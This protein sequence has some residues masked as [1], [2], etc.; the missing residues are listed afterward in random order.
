MAPSPKRLRSN[1]NDSPM[2]QSVADTCIS[3]AEPADIKVTINVQHPSPKKEVNGCHKA[4]DYPAVETAAQELLHGKAP[5]TAAVVEKKLEDAACTVGVTSSVGSATARHV[6]CA[7]EDPLTTDGPVQV[8]SPHHNAWDTSEVQESEPSDVDQRQVKSSPEVSYPSQRDLTN[9]EAD[10]AQIDITSPQHCKQTKIEQKARDVDSNTVSTCE[11]SRVREPEPEDL[12][13][14]TVFSDEP[15]EL[16]RVPPQLFWR[17]KDNLCWLDALLVALVNCKR[18]R[19]SRPNQEPQQSPVWQLIKGYNE[20]CAAV[21]AHQQ[22]G[23]DGVVRVPNQVLQ[24]ANSDLQSLRMSV[25]QLLQPKLHCKLGQRE[26]PVFAMPLLL[27]SD[28]WAEPLFQLTFHWEFKCSK[29]KTSTNLGVMKPLPTFTNIVSDWHPLHAAHLA[30]CNVCSQKNQKRTMVL[31]RV[32][33]VFALHFVGGLPDSDVRTYSFTFQGKRYSVTTVIQY[34]QHLKHFVTWIHKPDGSWLEFDDLKHPACT[35]H[36]K[37]PVPAKDIHIVFWEMEVD[38]EPH[39]CS[40]STTVTESPLPKNEINRSLTEKDFMADEL[41]AQSPDQSLLISQNDTDIVCALT[42][43]GENSMNTT[44][45][46]GV[47]TSIGSTTLLDTFEGLTHN[48]IVT[49]TLWEVKDSEPGPLND[50]EQTPDVSLPSRN[51]SP[52]SILTPDSSSTL[53]SSEMPQGPAADD[54]TPHTSDRETV[55][56]SSSD[57]SYV[58]GSRKRPRG[59]GRGRAKANSKNKSR[60][61]GEKAVLANVAQAISPSALRNSE[62]VLP[63]RLEATSQDDSTPPVESTQEVS[64]VSSTKISPQPMSKRCPELPPSMDQNARWSYLLSRHPLN[65]AH[66]NITK[67]IPAHTTDSTTKVKPTVPNHSTPNP[68]RRQR[69]PVEHFSKP[70]LC[71]ED[72]EALLRKAADMY[73]AFSAKKSN[74]STLSHTPLLP[75]LPTQKMA[76]LAPRDDKSKASQSITPF[77]QKPPLNASTVS[78]TSPS[79]PGVTGLPQISAKKHSSQLMKVPPG[80]SDTEA[81]RYKLFK[82]LKAKKKKLAKLNQLLGYQQGVGGEANLKPDSTDLSSPHTVTSSTY[83]SSNCDDFLADFLSPA[84]TASNLSPDSTGLLEM[85]TSGQDGGEHLD[86]GGNTIGG[87]S[88]VNTVAGGSLTTN[89]DNFLEEFISETAAQ[90]QTEM[91]REAL[92]ALDLFF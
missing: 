91:E 77:S 24:K 66:S 3:Q 89:S 86:Y 17:N 85:L 9:K 87:A 48:D 92:S 51:G 32:P 52:E 55:D 29:C 14:A 46:A 10:P 23:R 31:E 35:A 2:L 67:I 73:G 49:L 4:S 38:E 54:S 64:P 74:T 30:P 65:Q 33:P 80:L 61:K 20:A 12:S 26:T 44:V 72:S 88:Q 41:L 7:S 40:P 45:T 79:P 16:V 22:T 78:D 11:D 60:Q 36:T 5:T 19:K 71:R 59:R 56:D 34:D 75:S 21:Q 27:M 63:T 39:A 58:P 57:P 13:P 76:P 90:Q 82:K 15:D 47:D 83:D 18:L 62:T 68:V 53:I 50:K 37:L 8:L 42:V 6:H 25:F 70:Q 28:S 1:E 43:T 81:L 84:T 69:T